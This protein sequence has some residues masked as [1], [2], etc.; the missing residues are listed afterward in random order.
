MFLN[1]EGTHFWDISKIR[2]GY[3]KKDLNKSEIPYRKIHI[4]RHTF[5]STM[6]SSGEDV[7]YVSKIA[8]HSSTK[9]TLEVYSKYI[10]NKNRNFGKIFNE[11]F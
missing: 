11:S 3:W 10:P 7:N 1:N 5:C 8:G 9:M 6:I 4:T 2:T